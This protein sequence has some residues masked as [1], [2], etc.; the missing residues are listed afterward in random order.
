[1]NKCLRVN[2]PNIYDMKSILPKAETQ[3]TVV[4]V[5]LTKHLRMITEKLKSLFPVIAT[6]TLIRSLSKNM[7]GL[8]VQ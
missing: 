6:E 7:K 1:M 2:L 8:L 3:V 4:T 5:K